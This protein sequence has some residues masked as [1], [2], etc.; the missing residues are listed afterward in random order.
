[1][2]IEQLNQI[3]Q[4]ATLLHD[5]KTIESA[6][7]RLALSLTA[8]Y[9]DSDPIFLVVMNGGLIFSGKLLPLLNFPAQIDYC[10]ATRYRGETTGGKI[11]WKVRPNICLANRHVVI[12][13]D[14]LDEGHTLKAIID[15]CWE[16]NVSSV[17]TCVLIEKLHNRKAIANMQ[18]D[19][20]E[21][22]TDDHYVFGYG[23]DFN[24]YWRNTNEIYIYNPIEVANQ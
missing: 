23:M 14:I 10:H 5:S 24:H 3:K 11:E 9:A 17:K 13:D 4:Q 15:D 16:Q 8:D 21:L 19:Y 12:L 1:M 7:S 2:N 20:C 18:P 22:T 6:L